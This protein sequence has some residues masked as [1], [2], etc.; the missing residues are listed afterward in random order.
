MASDG[1]M[2]AHIIPFGIG[3]QSLSVY[4]PTSGI[5]EH[6]GMEER[7]RE[8]L[9]H[10]IEGRSVN[11]VAAAADIQQSWLQRFLNPDGPSGIRK[12]NPVKLGAVAAVFGYT[13]ADLANRDLTKVEV[14][15]PSHLAR[16]D[17]AKVSVTV[18]ALNIVL[19]RRKLGTLDL[20]D[21]EDAEMFVTAYAEL[22]AMESSPQSEVAF[23]AVISDLVSK[24][25]QL[26]AKS[27]GEGQQAGGPH[28]K[29]ARKASAGR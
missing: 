3:A 1:F 18:Q 9:R 8:N 15:A 7:I 6:G 29:E 26:R 22:E 14:L 23:G 20:A 10:L 4:V 11:G 25:E 17:P 12:A 5:R 27:G 28:R 24:R 21:P 19:A 13:F 2:A 16:L